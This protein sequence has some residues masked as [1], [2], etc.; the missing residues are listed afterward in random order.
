LGQCF[1]LAIK[2]G[3]LSQAPYIRQLTEDNIREDCFNEEDFGKFVENLPQDLRDFVRFAAACGVRKGELS[4]YRWDMLKG[5]T[6]HVPAR[7]CKN[8]NGRVLPLV[9]EMLEIVK[10]QKARRQVEINGVFEIC[11]FI[12]HRDG[13]TKAIGEF[14]KIVEVGTPQ[15]EA[16]RLFVPRLAQIRGS[17]ATRRGNSARYFDG[18]YRT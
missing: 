2:Q 8:R 11:P 12:F 5:E 4:A 15:G 13:E 17:G 10:R 3:Q 7:I 16:F 6:L 9:G 14:K 18:D 1:A